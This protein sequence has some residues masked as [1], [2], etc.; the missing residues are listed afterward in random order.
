MNYSKEY[1]NNEA[2]GLF[3]VDKINHLYH[4]NNQRI[5]YETDSKEFDIHHQDLKAAIS[6]MKETVEQTLK[7]NDLL[8]SAKKLLI[9]LNKHWPGINCIY[10]SPRNPPWIT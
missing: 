7:G 9:S 5:Q 8:P 4:L 3:W 2:F 10:L 6:A 1:P